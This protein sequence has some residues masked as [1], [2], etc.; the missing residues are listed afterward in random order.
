MRDREIESS[1]QSQFEYNLCV[2]HPLANES[3]IQGPYPV[4]LYAH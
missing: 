1:L 4:K 3:I 2:E